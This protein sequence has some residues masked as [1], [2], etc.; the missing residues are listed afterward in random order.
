LAARGALI[1]KKGREF[2]AKR[3]CKS[4]VIVERKRNIFGGRRAVVALIF[5][6][7]YIWATTAH[8]PPKIA[9]DSSLRSEL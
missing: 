8:R 4:A 6:K 7:E 3:F 9:R 1:F 5:L 2:G